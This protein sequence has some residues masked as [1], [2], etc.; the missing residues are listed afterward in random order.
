MPKR[1]LISDHYDRIAKKSSTLSKSMLELLTSYPIRAFNN[2]VKAS[3]ISTTLCAG[4]QNVVLD[5]CCGKGGD[6]SNYS[7]EGSVCNYVGIDISKNSVTEARR[8]LSK[9]RLAG[10]VLCGD[11]SKS[12]TW[13]HI[14]DVCPSADVVSMQFALHYFFDDEARLRTVLSNISAMLHPGGTFITTT[15]NSRRIVSHLKE[16]MQFDGLSFSL[17][18]EQSEEDWPSKEEFG[19]SY[20]FTLSNCVK[21]VEE[22]LLPTPTLT[23]L[24]G[25]YNLCLVKA[26]PLQSFMLEQYKNPELFKLLHKMH[27]LN[28]NDSVSK[29]AWELA[30]IYIVYVF[31]KMN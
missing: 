14:L 26:S 20:T 31:K 3:L 2:W 8:R 28:D 7:R 13:G 16:N 1:S 6:I 17:C 4:P 12:K 11:V 21:G 25:D 22:Y 29:D 27:V 9:S 23:R 15:T 10:T 30:D 19:Q 5:L 18:R 24:A